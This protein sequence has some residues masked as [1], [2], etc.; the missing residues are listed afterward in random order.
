MESSMLPD[1]LDQIENSLTHFGAELFLI[2]GILILTI[3]GL[4]W[5]KK[6][7][8]IHTLAL[9]ILAATLIPEV[10]QLKEASRLIFSGMFR[11]GNSFA[12]Y[13]KILFCVSGLLTAVMT[14]RG[15]RTQERLSEYYVLVFS[16]ILGANLLVMSENLVIL[17]L[18]MEL[19]S[20]CS[21]LLTGFSFEKRSTEGSLKYFLFGSISSAVM[22]YGFSILYG[23]FGTFSFSAFQLPPAEAMP[24]FYIAGT[25]SLTGF[26]FKIAAAPMHPW[27]PD[28]YEAAP[29]PI[30]AFF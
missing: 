1:N 13:L 28:V 3:A 2:G 4:I 20:I 9:T 25:F 27:A 12:D 10:L 14:L 5:K 15:E 29:M 21:Y 30:V 16:V 24:L 6:S 18:A 17:F 7:T 22:L 23:I 8:L 26:L 11:T 19:I